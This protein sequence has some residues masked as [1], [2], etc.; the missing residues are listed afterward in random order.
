MNS[1][2]Q[3][4]PSSPAEQTRLTMVPKQAS[5]A[6]SEPSLELVVAENTVVNAD[7]DTGPAIALPATE[8][9]TEQLS[10]MLK[11]TLGLQASDLTLLCRAQETTKE[12]PEARTEFT[13]MAMQI[14][15]D[16]GADPRMKEWIRE[17]LAKPGMSPSPREQQHKACWARAV[18]KDCQASPAE[19]RW[20]TT[21]L[22]KAGVPK[23]IL[24]AEKPIIVFP[25]ETKPPPLTIDLKGKTPSAFQPARP[26]D[27]PPPPPTGTTA[28]STAKDK[29]AKR[30][31]P[32]FTSANGTAYA[33]DQ[34][35]KVATEASAKKGEDGTSVGQG[36]R[37]EWAQ[38]RE[39]HK[40]EIEVRKNAAAEYNVPGSL[41]NTESMFHRFG[42]VT[43]AYPTDS[44]EYHFGR[45][46]ILFRNALGK[47]Y[48][49]GSLTCEEET[50][51]EGAQGLAY[52]APLLWRLMCSC[53]GYKPRPM[54][55]MGVVEIIVGPQTYPS[56]F[57][58]AVPEKWMLPGLLQ[59]V[60]VGSLDMRR[61]LETCVAR[62][63]QDHRVAIDGRNLDWAVEVW[64]LRQ[65]MWVPL[66]AIVTL[67]HFILRRNGKPDY[68]LAV[69][70]RVHIKS[71]TTRE[72]DVAACRA[73]NKHRLSS[74]GV[75]LHAA[76]TTRAGPRPDSEAHAMSAA[77]WGPAVPYQRMTHL[78]ALYEKICARAEAD[79]VDEDDP[80]NWGRGPD[81]DDTEQT[82]EQGYTEYYD[83]QDW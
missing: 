64:S 71:W 82:S 22:E 75:G 70:V 55:I 72:E 41:R 51:L 73:A 50:F 66:E 25:W 57:T 21:E 77:L 6:A 76:L 32:T 16:G 80:A 58:Y 3:S 60:R 30:K 2:S 63:S 28:A 36:K 17:E 67:P 52:A 26:A 11:A 74:D 5:P 83:G 23:D 46:G 4:K 10:A 24:D 78:Q 12:S 53:S 1:C 18:L 47:K 27:A 54:A 14:L 37:M 20:A 62:V 33:E 31:S 69:R 9:S 15:A 48:F 45:R 8:P 44:E 42:D 40:R 39:E 68:D 7:T 59:L 34:G 81:T 19:K 43:A 79:V 61:E 35:R 13:R 49:V 56:G 38:R 29:K 65:Q